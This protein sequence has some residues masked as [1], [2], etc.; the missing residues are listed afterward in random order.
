M[1]VSNP[2]QRAV[3]HQHA[4]GSVQ[5]HG[6]LTERRLHEGGKYRDRVALQAVSKRGAACHGID[7]CAMLRHSSGTTRNFIIKELS[8]EI[9]LGRVPEAFE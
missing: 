6:R 2:P 5:I 1:L 4:I 3:A 8:N 9:D 7:N